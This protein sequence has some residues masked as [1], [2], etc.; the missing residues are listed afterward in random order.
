MARLEPQ[1]RCF[2]CGYDIS[3]VPL[4]ATCPECGLTA[5]ESFSKSHL[6]RPRTRFRLTL[7]IGSAMIACGIC[8]YLLNGVA[9]IA[10][11]RLVHLNDDERWS[12]R[13]TAMT[14]GQLLWYAGGLLFASSERDSVELRQD[15][16]VRRTTQ[17][18]CLTSAVCA[19]LS[20]VYWAG[21]ESA[22]NSILG[23]ISRFSGIVLILLLAAMMLRV[24]QIAPRL[25]SNGVDKFARFLC[26][27]GPVI[28]A[29]QFFRIATPYSDIARFGVDVLQFALFSWIA[30]RLFFIPSARKRAAVV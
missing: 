7:L 29:A 21:P 2:A 17:V 23:G 24:Q 22:F 16:L 18:L 13:V 26:V 6:I 5:A 14:I 15:R 11:S 30:V 20:R 28:L 3:S 9:A 27:T 8:T 10:I 4:T 1:D 19:A 12:L 25:P